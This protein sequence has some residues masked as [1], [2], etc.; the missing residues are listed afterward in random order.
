MEASIWEYTGRES[1]VFKE[2]D[3][4]KDEEEDTIIPEQEMV[5]PPLSAIEINTGWT[6]V[7][8]I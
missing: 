8:S 5:S 1:S 4:A 6:R 2:E 3:S 7:P